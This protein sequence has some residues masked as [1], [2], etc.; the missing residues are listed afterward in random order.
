MQSEKNK[1]VPPSSD[2]EL[3]QPSPIHPPPPAP[4]FMLTP[5]MPTGS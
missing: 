5:T 1:E 2:Q 4:S 3:S